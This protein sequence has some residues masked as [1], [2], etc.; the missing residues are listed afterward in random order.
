MVVLLGTGVAM[1]AGFLLGGLVIAPVLYPPPR[2]FLD[3][4]P[5]F[6]AVEAA[7]VSAPVGGLA[8]FYSLVK[9]A[10]WR[11]EADE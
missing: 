9:Y 8:A 6:L 4:E 5:L 1:G 3:M 10:R 2:P 7:F 11:N